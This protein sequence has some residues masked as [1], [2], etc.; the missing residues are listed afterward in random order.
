[1]A[2][3]HELFALVRDITLGSVLEMEMAVA[4]TLR[5]TDSKSGGRRSRAR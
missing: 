1:M 5:M 3:I 2:E 4:A